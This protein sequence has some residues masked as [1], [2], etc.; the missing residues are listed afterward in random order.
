MKLLSTLG[1]VCIGLGAAGVGCSSSSSNNT[2]TG[3]GGASGSSSGGSTGGGDT[4]TATSGCVTPPPS[5]STPTAATASHNYALK[6]LYLGDRPRGQTAADPNAWQTFGYNLDNL[7]TNAASTDVCTLAPM[8]PKSNQT[9]GNG[10]IDNSFGQ[11]ILPIVLSAG[12]DVSTTLNSSIQ[13]GV[14]SLLQYIQGIDDTAIPQTASGLT[15]VLLSGGDYRQLDAGAPAF[16]MTTHWPVA[17]DLLTCGPTCPAGSDPVKDAKVKYPSAY[18]VNGTFVNG[19]PSDVTLSLTIGNQPLTLV[20]HSSVITFDHPAAGKATNGT[21][22]GVIAT[23]DLLTAVQGIAG[24][25]SRNLCGGA[26]FDSIK[27]AILQASDIIL[28][29]DGT[30]S[31]KA[32][33]ECNA[34]SIG[35]G[36]EAVEIA[37]PTAADVVGPTPPGPDPCADA[38]TE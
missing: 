8:A 3:D 35:L 33:V 11:N 16:D 15:G 20:A 7:T 37:A 32:G 5:P 21:I 28:S 4:C 25:I 1:L 9:D 36:F 17:P 13:Q 38:G 26:A 23:N 22:A 31:N 12:G 24:H 14:F 30:I 18:I 2:P 27:S 10:G 6:A 19:S 34:I 29:S